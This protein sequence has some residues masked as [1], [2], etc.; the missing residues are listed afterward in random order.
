MGWFILGLLLGYVIGK[1]PYQKG[2]PIDYSKV[3]EKLRNE[4][5]IAQNLNQSLL[6]DKRSLQEQLWKSKNAS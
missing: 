1:E 4:L 5:S 6:A 3:D 2:S